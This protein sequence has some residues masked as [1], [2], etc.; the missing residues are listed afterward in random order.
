MKY[1]EYKFSELLSN[2]VDNRGKTCPVADSGLPLI[3]TNCI[4]N[5]S[6]YPAFDKIRYVDEKTYQE[7][8]RSHPIPGDLIFVTKGSPGRVCMTPNP[9]NFCIAQDMVAIRADEKIVYPKYLFAALRSDIVQE[10]I[11]NMHVGSLIP[12]FK[13]G[14]FDKLW[15]PVTDM[16]TQRY[17][18][19]LYF[20]ISSKIELNNQ[21]NRTL[22]ATAQAIFKQW[23][24][25]FE[26]PVN[27][28]LQGE[29]GPLAVGEVGY[30]SSGGKM[31]DSE[32]GL[33]PEGW[34]VGDISNIS[35]LNPETWNNQN[36]PDV[37]KYVDLANTK[38]GFIN[39]IQTFNSENAPSRAKRVLRVNDTII[40]TV[41]PG[42]RSLAYIYEDGLTG[43]T[44]FAVI[45]ADKKIYQEY[46]NLLLT[47]N[48]AIEYFT[49]LADGAAY[50]AIK[51]EVIYQYQI[52][53]PA[54]NV[55]SEFHKVIEPIF[56]RIGCNYFQ[57]QT[58][59][60]LRDSL[61]PKLMSGELR[62]PEEIVKNYEDVV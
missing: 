15:I 3:A 19:D 26:F 25:D 18:G 6:L 58:L 4:S 28:L 14:D 37:I 44:G 23:F 54:D 31:I 1:I 35:K 60:T 34:C 40:G 9:V 51:P 57:S 48:E 10:R 53:K 30:K 55:L 46:I 49:H 56:N 13:K 22:E 21:M 33:I 24:V 29:G 59:S 38:N 20:N 52:I 8:F 39:D 11:V 45:R 7:W 61:L 36:I 12:H 16:N 2:I 50:P 32:L 47:S 17:I 27:P 43:S 41:R 5:E 62:V 42:N